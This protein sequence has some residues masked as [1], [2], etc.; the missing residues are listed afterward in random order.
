MRKIHQLDD[1]ECNWY[2]DLPRE[3]GANGTKLL[4]P[5]LKQFEGTGTDAQAKKLELKIQLA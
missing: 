5:I 1:E 3:I 4:E 2:H